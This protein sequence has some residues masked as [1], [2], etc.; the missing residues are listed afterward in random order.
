MSPIALFIIELGAGDIFLFSPRTRC[1]KVDNLLAP[2]PPQ[3]IKYSSLSPPPPLRV[4]IYIPICI[5]RT[6]IIN[7]SIIPKHKQ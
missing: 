5:D 7:S 1:Y 6:L 4:R 2:H 3:I